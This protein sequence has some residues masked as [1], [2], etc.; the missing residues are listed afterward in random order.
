[1]TYRKT[2][3]VLLARAKKMRREPTP[4]E[5]K[6][7]LALRAKRLGNAKFSR[8]VVIEPFIVDFASRKL[9]LVIEIDGDTH[10]FSDEDDL[11][12]TRFL[13]KQGYRIMRFT[14]AEVMGNM[15]GVLR[16]IEEKLQDAPLPN[17]LPAGE[18][19]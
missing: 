10:D 1:M 19:E 5:R 8:Q 2:D 6:L 4:A 15:E 14:N 17:P 7:W 12:R 16:A 9:G 3:P 11:R 18:R 13:E